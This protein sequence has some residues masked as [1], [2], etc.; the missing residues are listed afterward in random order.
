MPRA[1]WQRRYLGGMSQ[2]TPPLPPR[3]TGLKRWM[4]RC[5]QGV[6][7]P[8]GRLRVEVLQQSIDVIRHLLAEEVGPDLG[9]SAGF[10]SLDGD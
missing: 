8:S 6:A 3:W 4:I 9:I 2:W 10:N 7:E 1:I 5:L